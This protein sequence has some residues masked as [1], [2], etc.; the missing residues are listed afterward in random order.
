MIRLLEEWRENLDKNYVI[1]GVLMDL[2]KAFDCVPRDFL[3]AK[4]AAYG[5][6]ESF[7]CYIYSY[8]LN[9]KQCVRINNINSDFL[10]VI[11]GVPQGSIVGPILFNCFFN[12]FFYVIEI[13]N[14]HNFA[15][16][17]TLTAFAN[18]IPNLI[19]LL[20]SESIVAIKWFKENKMIVNPG[21]FQ[22]IIL[23]KKKTNHT[24]E[25]IKI[26]NKAVKVKSLVKLLGFQIDDEL[27]FNLHIVN[28]CRSAANRLNALTRLRKFLG[29]EEKKVLIN[30]YFY[31]N[32]C[33]LVW[34]FSHAKSLKKVEALQKRALR[35]LYND[36]NTPL[37]EILKKSGK[38]CM[39]VNRLSYLCIEIY[40]S[41]NNINPSFMKQIFQLRETNRTV[42]NQYKLNL[43]VPKVNQVSYGGKS[44]RFYGPKIWNS[45]PLHVKTSENLKLSKTSF[46]IGMVVHV[47]V[48][49]VRVE[50]NLFC[51]KSSSYQS[52]TQHPL[53]LYT[54]HIQF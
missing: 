33:P 35:F 42:R 22:A 11:S 21:K 20:G 30:S 54:P 2:S 8:L 36:Y 13:A 1:G 18:S 25:T 38:V 4:L 41:I 53:T 31:S 48:G 14:A 7:L 27:N 51:L 52:S 15:G 40:K 12:D 29:F 9:R 46:K 37:L 10:T 45:L 16:D 49:C 23:D 47:T 32:Y 43:S 50:L 5:V 6:N 26:D 34:M 44:L 3:L 24:Q 17:N 28:I 19:H 39:E